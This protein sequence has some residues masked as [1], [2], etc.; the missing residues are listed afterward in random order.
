MD[1]ECAGKMFLQWA[2]IETNPP[3]LPYKCHKCNTEKILTS[4]TTF[5]I[6]ELT[7]LPISDDSIHYRMTSER[8]GHVDFSIVDGE[9]CAYGWE[10][11]GDGRVFLAELEKHAAENKLRLTIPTVLNPALEKILRDNGYTMGKVPCQDDMC[12][13]WRKGKETAEVMA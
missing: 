6:T 8:G 1:C 12:E 4:E 2:K 11:P 7:D 3:A 10:C 13:L 5:K 9:M